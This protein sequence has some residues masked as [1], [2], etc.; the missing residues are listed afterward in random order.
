MLKIRLM[1]IGARQRPFYRIVVVDER[2]KRNGAYL[3]LLGTY[4]P[5]SEPKD[6]KIDKQKLE[7]W[8][9]KGA[10]KSDGL[11]RILKEAPERHRK[12]K[13]GQAESGKSEVKPA[14]SEESKEGETHDD[15]VTKEPVETTA[16]EKAPDELKEESVA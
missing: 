13:K 3:D 6:I 16:E 11:L 15:A 10:Q 4:D 9:K 2:N 12:P 5:L 7:D 14:Q 8:L 1:R